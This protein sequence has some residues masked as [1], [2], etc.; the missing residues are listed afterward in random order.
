V[1]AVIRR[2][3]PSDIPAALRLTQTAGWNQTAHDWQTLLR[4]APETCFALECDGAA[5][6]TTTA[7]CYGRAL[8]WIGMV[9]TDPQHRR[10]G[11][12]RRLLEHALGTLAAREI[13]WMKLDATGMGAPLY[14]ALG[15]DEE[16]AVER[17][18]RAASPGG[19]SRAWSYAP[20]HALDRTAFGA[21]RSSLLEML[22]PAGAASLHEEAYAMG[23]PGS[24]AAYFGP[25]VSRS[26]DAARELLAWFLAGHASEPA[27]WDLLPG[28]AAAVRL[29]CENGFQ[30]LR[31]LLR[32]VRAG[33][34]Q[35]PPLARE[36]SLVFAMEGFEC[37]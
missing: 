20:C 10:R 32:M 27:Y 28:N 2:L 9:L 18:G 5:V 36:D 19:G 23:R 15:F 37:G 17:W 26:T 1:S 31:R 22:A 29:A 30:P 35:A 14:R 8:A 11:Y 24:Q 21:D 4:L 3:T 33:A 6:A 12:A 7:I 16:C 25:C 34:R 13:S